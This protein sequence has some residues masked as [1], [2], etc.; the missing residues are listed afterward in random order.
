MPYDVNCALVPAALRSIYQLSKAGIFPTHP[1]WTRQAKHYSRVWE[2]TTLRFFSVK[3]PASEVKSRLDNYK[4]L[5]DFRG[6]TQAESISGEEI[7]FHALALDGNNGLEKVEV[8]NTDDCFRLF[9]I[10]D[11]NQIQASK[12]IDQTANNV[13]RRFPAGLMTDVSLV[14]ANP[15]YGLEAVYAS[16][17]TTSAYHGPVVWSWQLAMMAKGFEIQL[18]RC[19]EKHTKIPLFCR[20][21]K[22]HSNVV[23]AYNVLWDSIEKNKQLLS[24]E[25]WSWVYRDGKFV[26]Y[27][28]GAL[29]PQKGVAAGATGKFK[30]GKGGFALR[31]FCLLM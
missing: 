15:A 7:N 4:K 1:E 31:I 8:M 25:V 19:H 14:V 22:V 17:W 13:R 9:L 27:P 26:Q 28:L 20:Q 11:T 21:T 16:N 12:F 29:P 23:Q 18:E 5:S 24:S 30:C 3:I 10:N 2:N 6:P